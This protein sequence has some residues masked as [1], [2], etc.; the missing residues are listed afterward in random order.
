MAT[1]PYSADT[2]RGE[3]RFFF[4][5]A[6]VMSAAIVGGFAFNLL[7]GISSFDVPWLVHIHAFVM[8]VWVALYLTQNTLIFSD[9]IAVHRRLGW[10]SVVWLP[11]I[12]VLGTLMTRWAVQEHG[13]PPFLEVNEFL[14]SNPLLLLLCVSLAGWAVTVRANTGWH[15]RLMY[16]SF[17]ILTGPGIGRLGAPL[18]FRIEPWGWWMIVGGGAVLFIGIAMI[19]DKRRYGAVHPA[20]FWALGLILGVQLVADLV[21]YSDWGVNFT[22]SYVAGLP[23]SARPMGAFVPP[24]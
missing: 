15:R 21:A 3:A 18:W 13:V 23:G 16:G 4:T 2:D 1:I 12:L 17:T 24:A 22:Q 9:N 10:L 19:A 11:A 5:M 7:M 20:W 6:C 8:F 14:F